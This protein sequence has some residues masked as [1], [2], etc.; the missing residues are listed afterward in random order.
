MSGYSRRRI[1]ENDRPE[2]RNRF[3]VFDGDSEDEEVSDDGELTDDDMPELRTQDFMSSEVEEATSEE[4][5]SEDDGHWYL[6]VIRAE[7]IYQQCKT[8]FTNETYVYFYF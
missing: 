7:Q 3:D 8:F 2:V 4:E 1:A 5:E 6:F